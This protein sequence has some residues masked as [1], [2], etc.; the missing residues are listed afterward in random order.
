MESRIKRSWR[1]GV[2]K[3]QAFLVAYARGFFPVLVVAHEFRERERNRLGLAPDY[4]VQ[5]PAHFQ[6]LFRE[7]GRMDAD[8]KDFGIRQNGLEPVNRLQIRFDGPRGGVDHHH[9]GLEFARQLCQFF[10]VNIFH[11]AVADPAFVSFEL[12]P[13]GDARQADRRPDRS[14]C[15]PAL[16]APSLPDHLHAVR[17]SPQMVA[18]LAAA[19]AR[20]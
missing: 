12:K 9:F 4:S 16:H 3:K 13:R 7:C 2:V 15:A 11:D 10:K 14:P 19:R 17:R 1:R 20:R 5:A 6:G 18:E 8:H